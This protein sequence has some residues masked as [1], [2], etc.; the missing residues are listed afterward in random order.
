MKITPANIANLGI[1]WVVDSPCGACNRFGVNAD[2]VLDG[3]EGGTSAYVSPI[4]FADNF[5]SQ[6]WV[7]YLQTSILFE[8][9][10][11]LHKLQIRAVVHHGGNCGND[12][13]DVKWSNAITVLIDGNFTPEADSIAT[14][15]KRLSCDAQLAKPIDLVTGRM[16]YDKTDLRIQAPLPLEFTRRYDSAST[17]DLKL[18]YGWQHNFMV[19]LENL[20]YGPSHTF[21]NEEMR[22]ITFNKGCD[23][24]LSDDECVGVWEPNVVDH[25]SLKEGANSTWEVREKDGKTYTFNNA[26]VL[27]HITDRNGN[28]LTLGYVN[29][30]LTTVSDDF[31]R[32]IQIDY[33]SGSPGLIETVSA[34]GRSVTY[35]YDDNDNLRHATYSDGD[36]I[37]YRYASSD[38]HDMTKALDALGHV[39]EEHV[40][41]DG[42][43]I[44][45]KQDG[46]NY[47]YD[48]QYGNSTSTTRTV[49]DALDHETAYTLDL[50][51][52]VP[53][54][55]AGPSCSSCGGGGASTEKEY[56]D[57]LNLTSITDAE[58]IETHLS[59]YDL[60][61]NAGTRIENAQGEEEDQ[62][63]TSYL[64]DLDW[65]RP[66]EIRVATL[67]TGDCAEHHP[68]KV[69][70]YEYN[71]SN[72]NLEI[73]ET[74]GCN[75]D[76][77]IIQARSYTYDAHGQIESVTGPRDEDLTA[78]DYYD[79]DDDDMDLRGRL[80]TV[81]NARGHV[82]TYADYDYFG[83]A[84][85]VIDPNGV[86][87]TR[88][89]NFKDQVLTETLGGTLELV[90]ENV[91]DLVGNLHRV[92][93]PKCVAAGTGSCEFSVQYD[94]DGVNRLVRIRD[95]E[96]N[97]IRYS[98]DKAGNRIREEFGDSSSSVNRFTNFTYDPLNRL[99]YV[100]FVDAPPSS[101]PDDSSSTLTYFKYTYFD[102][103]MRHTERDPK[104]HVT[105]F[106]YDPFKRAKTVSQ[107]VGSNTL[108]TSYEYDIQGNVSDVTDPRNL[109]THY[110]NGDLG[111]RLGVSSPDTEQTLY[112]YD[113]AGNLLT[114]TNADGITVTREYDELSRLRTTTYP[115]S[116]LNVANSYDSDQVTFGI[117]R[118]TG[119]ADQ[120]GTTTFEYER[121]GLLVSEERTINDWTYVTG[122]GYDANGNILGIK[123]PAS[124]TA[125][126]EGVVNYEY[127][128]ADR[129]SRVTTDL[130]DQTA[131]VAND[132]HYEPFGPR[133]E[134][135]FGN[136]LVDTRSF[137]SRYQLG[138]WTL[139]NLLSYTH[140]FDRDGN[141][142][143]LADNLGSDDRTFGYDEIHRLTTATGPWCTESPQSDCTACTGDTTYTYDENGNRLCKG[144]SGA[145]T[146]YAYTAGTNRL[147]SSGGDEQASYSYDHQGSVIGDGAHSYE[148][149]DAARLATVDDSTTASY[150]YD[151]EGHRVLKSSDART[152]YFYDQSGRLLTEITLGE[153]EGSGVGTDYLYLPDGPIARVDW[154][155]PENWGECPPGLGSGECEPLLA[156]ADL[157]YYHT[158]HVGTPIALT[159]GSGAPIWRAV[160][161]PF[162]DEYHSNALSISA[163]SS[164]LRFPGQYFDSETG[165]HQNWFRDYSPSTGRYEE[166]DP[167][168]LDAGPNSYG[169][170]GGNPLMTFDPEGLYSWSDVPT[171]W[172]H[173]C[174]GSGTDWSTS[175]SSLNWGDTASQIG[176]EI[177]SMV[178]GQC[179]NTTIPVDLLSQGQTAGADRFIVGRH[180]IRTKGSIE[181]RCDCSWKFMGRM[182][183]ARGYD[184]YDFD[185]SN[186]GV[187][188]EAVV[189]V[190]RSSCRSSAKRF[191]IVITGSQ[192]LLLS[193]KIDGESCCGR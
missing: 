47:E 164:N 70:S 64:Y 8:Q 98:Y 1:R 166:S 139:G 143:T 63:E 179:R 126:R 155:V 152:L 3:G 19:R 125:A 171:A 78:Y 135:T 120:L 61:G 129:V 182:S 105:S 44:N 55:I 53:T 101:P 15:T 167:L 123:Y 83:N 142:T 62:R 156:T 17:A 160:F 127:D 85:T 168:G 185:R 115:D 119:V 37:E 108:T 146:T 169:Y 16:Y 73:E 12:Q 71:P 191:D 128:D 40:Y 26:G 79:D 150:L 54:G 59:D 76:D 104:N 10:T 175:F 124:N 148:Y 144:E 165:L 14:C 32:S 131:T 77:E 153:S 31:G 29:N 20:S 56:D 18:G 121:R 91:Y 27:Q 106:S 163:V 145:V 45:T 48:I 38:V 13:Y 181:L 80:H 66:K 6:E 102:D 68:R 184:P 173:Y 140:Q 5:G 178:G 133:S 60:L 92:R 4:L 41:Q 43:V 25:M 109:T 35:D 132:F 134:L 103:G 154:T 7:S 52:G 28:Q 192:D 149:S 94:Y 107:T 162:G 42:K 82:T 9:W 65:D 141:L 158:D 111:W 2:F 117:G 93:K 118:R 84:R 24:E 21:I 33:Y 69:T 89:F 122:Y 57:S 67:G 190:G 96:G 186:R 46:G 172:D 99:E 187:I 88:T 116:D 11:C 188:G 49:T 136:T 130:S 110:T 81:T 51:K 170:V 137:D 90:T 58:G 161:R 151:P 74:V 34:D 87:T 36:V 100:Y 112:T 147:A 177:K 174:D 114:S 97:E 193:G 138:T 30:Q 50:F 159:D 176:D 113:T 75:G 22:P 183:S 72:G 23:P 157:F 189:G 86:V 39:I 95:A 180:S